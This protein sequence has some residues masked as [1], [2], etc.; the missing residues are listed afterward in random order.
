MKTRHTTLSTFLT[1]LL[2][3]PFITLLAQHHC[4]NGHNHSAEHLQFIAN[5]NQWHSN[6]LYRAGLGGIDNVFLEQNAFTYQFHDTEAVAELHEVIKSSYAVQAAHIVEGHAYRVRFVGSN[7]SPVVGS[8]K[9]TQYHNYFLGNDPAK[10]ASKVPV[11]RKV[12]Y[13]N[14]YDDIQ[15]IA[16]SQDGLFKYDFVV[17][18]QADVG[19]I[20]LAYEGADAVFL[21]EDK[22]HIVTNVGMIREYKPYAYQ[23]IDGKTEEVN[24]TFELDGNLVRFHLPDGYD[25]TVP[26]VID[27]VVVGATLSGTSF[28]QNFGHTASF[29]NDGNMISGGISF[30]FGYPTTAGAFQLTFAGGNMDMAITKYT[31]DGSAQIYATYIGGSD[32]DY[33][34]SMISDDNGQLCVYGT[35]GSTNFPTTANAIQTDFGGNADI[36]VV[37]LNADGTA[38]VGGTYIGGTEADGRNYT[39]AIFNYGDTYRGEIMVDASGNVYVVSSSNSTDFPTTSNVVQPNNPSAD[40]A[41]SAVV[42]KLNSDLSTLY[43]STFLGSSGVDAGLGMKVDEAGNVY[44]VGGT[45]ASDFATTAGTYQSDWPGGEANGF[46]TV[47]S[48]NAQQILASTFF[49]SADGEEYNYFIDLDQ[50][51][52][53][54]VFGLT[55]GTIDATPGTYSYNPGSKQFLAAFSND[56]ESLIY[57]TVIGLGPDVFGFDFVPVAFM[58]DRCSNIYFSGYLA[59]SD[60]PVTPD[61]IL[62]EGT[63]DFY[64]AQLAPNATDLQYASYY[65][66]SYHVDGGTSRFDQGGVIYQA[67]CSGS[68]SALE[69][70]PNAFAPSQSTGWDVGIFKIDFEIEVVTASAVAAP[71]TSGCAPFTVDFSYTGLDAESVFW[72]FGTGDTS[73]EVTPTYTFQTPGTYM[74]M[75]VASGASTCN[76]TDTFYLQIDVMGN[77]TVL[78]EFSHCFTDNNPLFLDATTVNATYEWQDGSTAATYLAESQGNYW[79]DVSLP[80]CF[81]RDSFVVDSE[82]LDDSASIIATDVLCHGDFNGSIVFEYDGE[83]SDLEFS[84]SNGSSDPNIFDLPAGTYTVSVA[85]ASGCSDQFEAEVTQPEALD[86]VVVAVDHEIDDQSNGS[87]DVSLTGGTPPFTYQW[88]LDGVIISDQQNIDGLISGSYSLLV[89]DANGC[90]ISEENIFVENLVPVAEIDSNPTIIIQPNPSSGHFWVHLKLDTAEE[91]LVQIYDMLGRLIATTGKEMVLDEKSYSFDLSKM[92]GGV[93]PVKV[94]AGSAMVVEP[95]VVTN[96]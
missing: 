80:T 69:T 22:L 48:P 47:L 70:T 19:Q 50:D 13:E 95:V 29:D 40:T 9:Q 58:V 8:E 91:V 55:R 38:L 4:S 31:P 52:Q 83:V 18:P 35:T 54:H 26:L 33:P 75:Q 7:I 79:V 16:Y 92:P 61:A 49:G 88:S 44:V 93:Y 90:T 94:I 84:W 1:L 68:N 96:R 6:I 89:T 43:W 11:F 23:M 67:V 74:V 21:E 25:P 34:H 60:L 71:S 59:V 57:S 73:T 63:N 66:N 87:I 10:W 14:L 36:V 51:G 65:P 17:A 78:K 20:T 64:I 2:I 3:F 39:L 45:E 82:A 28:N 15:L 5:N 77:T 12:T 27:P 46:I 24:C 72:N 86:I 85:N 42:M 81:R 62:A 30:G 53:V 76:Q 37:K 41:Q 56:L 32:S